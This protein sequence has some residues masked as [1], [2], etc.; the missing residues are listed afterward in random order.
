MYSLFLV[1]EPLSYLALLAPCARAG[2]R[3]RSGSRRP[4]LRVATHPYGALVVG[5]QAL[6]VAAR[7]RRG[8]REAIGAFAAVGVLGIP[9]WIADLVLAGRFDVGVGGGGEQ[10]GGP[11]RCAGTSGHVLGDFTAGRCAAAGR[12]R[13]RRRRR[14]A[15][16]HDRRRALLVA[17]VVVDP[18]AGVRARPARAARPRPR[19]AT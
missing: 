7:A 10:L 16:V 3:G 17:A 14:L 18:D 12:A 19:R 2:A 4:S 15:A 6:Y 5:S 9:F 1:H 13:T 11:S 8:L